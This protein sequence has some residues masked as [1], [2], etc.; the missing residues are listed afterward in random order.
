MKALSLVLV[1][2]LAAFGCN[3]GGGDCEKAIANSMDVSKADLSKTPGVDATL[4]GKMKDLGIQH[5]KDDK[6]SGEVTKC[7][8]DAKTETDAQSCY[9]KMTA[10]QS[11]K[12]NKAAMELMTPPAASAGSAK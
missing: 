10:D 12:M 8:I 4:M 6:W 5:C 9:G 2:A 3:K 11:Q 1:L 7:M